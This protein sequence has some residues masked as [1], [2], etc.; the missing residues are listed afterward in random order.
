VVVFLDIDGVLNDYTVYDWD[1]EPQP[2]FAR[3]CVKAFN[4]IIEKTSALIV[5][6][7]SWR[8]LIHQ[9]H[10]SIK[11]FEE[12]LH[13]HG[14]RGKVIGCTPTPNDERWMDIKQWLD[15]HPTGRYV[16]LDDQID[17]GGPHPFVQ[18]K[19]DIGLTEADADRAIDLLLSSQVMFKGECNA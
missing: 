16:V 6:S 8:G 13:S 1:N 19:M 12:L 4:R 2:L 3:H 17:A 11:G 7:S 5:I 18:T 15:E 9:G 10:M 14:V